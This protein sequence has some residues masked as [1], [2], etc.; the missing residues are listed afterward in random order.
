MI[1]VILEKV[2]ECP[3]GKEKHENT[4]FFYKM[5]GDYYRYM[6][7]IAVGEEKT[8]KFSMMQYITENMILV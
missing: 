4:V 8:G 3:D 6:C 1:D 2:K 7:E 5:K